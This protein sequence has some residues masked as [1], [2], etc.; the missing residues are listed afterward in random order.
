MTLYQLPDMDTNV[1]TVNLQT[2]IASTV[3]DNWK[4]LDFNANWVQICFLVTLH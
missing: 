3:S 2:H 4:I 1:S